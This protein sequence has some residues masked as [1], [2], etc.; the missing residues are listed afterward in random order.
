MKIFR[1]RTTVLLVGLMCL[2]STGS[3]SAQTNESADIQQARFRDRIFS[4]G[5]LFGG[6]EEAE[7]TST[8]RWGREAEA[9]KPRVMLEPVKMPVYRGAAAGAPPRQTAS[10]SS[11]EGEPADALL[12]LVNRAIDVTSMRYLDVN[13]HTPWQIMHGVLA[14]REDLVLRSGNQYVRALDWISRGPTYRNQPWF[15]ATAHGGRAHPFN[16]PFHFEGHVNQFLALLSLSNLPYDHQFQ[17]A[18]G[19]TVTMADM[20]ENAKLTVSAREEITWTLWFLT[21]YI[22]QDSEWD[23]A[24]GEPW[25]MEQLVR[26]Q[27]QASVKAH[28]A[29]GRMDC[30]RWPMHGTPICR[31]IIHSGA[32]GSMRTRRFADTSKSPSRCRTAMAASRP[33]TSPG[34]ATARTTTSG[35]VFPGILSSV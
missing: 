35:F 15:E 6:R 32:R 12:K 30:S 26:I 11:A 5:R 17:V 29:E 27:T 7:D 25:S 21:H 1:L 20:I 14:L 22:D 3:V 13:T 10:T 33:S 16:V 8:D 19:K 9:A 24:A 18:G 34:P 4:S 31:S 28:P 2:V 23:N